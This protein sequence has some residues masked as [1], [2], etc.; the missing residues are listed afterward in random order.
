MS[1]KNQFWTSIRPVVDWVWSL[2]SYRWLVI[3]TYELMLPDDI[4]E[5]LMALRVLLNDSV[6]ANSYGVFE[7]G[8]Y[9]G[10]YPLGSL[11][12]SD[13]CRIGSNKAKRDIVQSIVG[14]ATWMAEPDPPTSEDLVEIR[15]AL[16]EIPDDIASYK[17][18]LDP[19]VDKDRLH[20]LGWI[21][22]EFNEH[23]FIDMKGE[24]LWI[25]VIGMD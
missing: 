7:E 24:R 25:V 8:N 10:P 9:H 19:Y 3:S 20:E 18:T 23:I 21:M 1:T 4:D 13:F 5:P 15:A 14:T 16:A 17:L 2:P 6:Y 11:L 12:T 22:W